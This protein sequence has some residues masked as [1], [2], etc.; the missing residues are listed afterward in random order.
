MDMNTGMEI[1]NMVMGGIIIFQED[2][3]KISK[4]FKNIKSF[5]PKDSKE[6][7]KYVLRSYKN[8]GPNFISLKS[9]NSNRW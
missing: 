4:M 8:Q 9:D 1:E 2:G 5:F 6:T 7:E 3:K